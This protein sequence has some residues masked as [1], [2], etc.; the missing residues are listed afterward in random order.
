MIERRGKN[1]RQIC[2]P[3]GA[4]IAESCMREEERHFV[5]FFVFIRI[6]SN[7]KSIGDR[8]ANA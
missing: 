3:M 2:L 7:V 8:G 1:E 6:E 5:S 4:Y